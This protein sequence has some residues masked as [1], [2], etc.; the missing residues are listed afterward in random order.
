MWTKIELEIAPFERKPNECKMKSHKPEDTLFA[1][2]MNK[3][4]ILCQKW[5]IFIKK[6]L[7]LDQ[8]QRLLQRLRN[9]TINHTAR[10]LLIVHV[11]TVCE[12][13]KTYE[14]STLAERGLECSTS[15]IGSLKTTPLMCVIYSSKNHRP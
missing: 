14:T 12:N 11:S 5:V 7:K 15:W 6:Y 4:R 1:K 13:E 8:I 10:V 2:K 3:T 9:G